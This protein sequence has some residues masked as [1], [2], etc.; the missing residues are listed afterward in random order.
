MTTLLPFLNACGAPFMHGRRGIGH[1]EAV[2]AQML[3]RAARDAAAPRPDPDSEVVRDFSY[4][5]GQFAGAENLSAIGWASVRTDLQ[6]RL[7]NWL[8]VQRLHAEHPELAAEDVSDPVVVV[9]LPRT[10]TTLVHN[11]LA[12]AEGHRGTLFWELLHPDLPLPAKETKKIIAGVESGQKVINL[13]APQM[14]DI[15]PQSAVK[16]DETA[17]LFF[18][19]PQHQ[20]R[21]LMPEYE[22]WENDR[23][24]RGDYVYLKQ[25]LQVL[26]H[27]REKRRWV[28]KNPIH[29][30]SLPELLETFPN[31]T[32]V[33]MHRGPATVMG[34]ICSLVET[35]HRLHLKRVDRHEIG[36]MCLDMLT[37]LVERGRAA[38]PG[39]TPQHLVDIP[40]DWLTASPHTAVPELYDLIGAKW[41]NR[42]AAG[43]DAILARPSRARKHDYAAQHYGLD[44][45]EID[46]AFGNY[47]SLAIATLPRR[48]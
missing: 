20:A 47:G 45:M 6:N 46:R 41:T 42:D 29:L 5:V 26:Q 43:L 31:A 44:E 9:G 48:N 34:S 25:V 39:I 2:V 32:I 17:F 16:A 18:H 7:T 24:T 21:A 35:S 27:G 33:W 14:L 8:R 22:K 37:R 19:G 23:D 40:Y 28:L 12:A 38:R 4:L 36:R 13:L 15:H 1:P 30:A 10:A 11:L 3:D